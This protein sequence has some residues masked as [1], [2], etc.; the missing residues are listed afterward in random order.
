MSTPRSPL[1]YASEGHQRAHQFL[2]EEA[3][4]L[5]TGEME[6]WLGLLTDDIRYVMPVQVTR[7]RGAG[8]TGPAMDHLDE[9][10][11]ALRLR[12]QRLATGHAWTEEPPSRT[13]HF[14]TN[15][16]TFPGPAAHELVVESA[17]LLWRSR[18]D[19]RPPELVSAGR[20]DLLRDDGYGGLRLARRLVRV[21]EAVLRTQ[22]LAIL[23]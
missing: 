20:D 9:D 15:V 21:D 4:L 2:V 23:L 18:G 13:R 11:H 10:L 17:V 8:A 7:S 16:R 6:A 5:D 22:N 14:V 12:V 1:P 19:D 3:H